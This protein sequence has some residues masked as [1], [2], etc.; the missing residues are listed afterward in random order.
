MTNTIP[1][2][3]R[4]IKYASLTL[5]AILS[6]STAAAY[7]LHKENR[8]LRAEVNQLHEDVSQVKPWAKDLKALRETLETSPRDLG[9]IQQATS[10]PQGARTTN[11]PLPGLVRRYGPSEAQVTLEVYSDFECS[12]CAG[13]H[14]VVK[15]I[16]DSARGNVSVIFK[17]VPVH[18]EASRIEAMAMECA[19]Q[20]AGNAGAFQM[21]DA[22]FQNTS[23][24]GR[25]LTTPMAA[26]ANQIGLDGVQFSRCVDSDYYMAKLKSDF[27]AAVKLGISQTPT[28]VVRNS[29]SGVSTTLSGTA[30]PEQLLQAMATVLK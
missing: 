14:P 9:A 2:Y 28:T 12:Y 29:R 18:G 20:Q 25:G 10:K 24:G 21:A 5:V 30:T 26:L 6:T 13:Y 11:E 22:L 15:S 16:A 4:A 19:G 27:E 7:F 23:G 8:E 3:E 1:R 17:H